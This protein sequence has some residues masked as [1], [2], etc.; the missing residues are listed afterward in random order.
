ML[1]QHNDV[2]LYYRTRL[3]S[4]YLGDALDLLKLLPDESVNLIMTSPPF[5]LTCKKDYGNPSPEA[6][7][8]WFMRFVDNFKRVLTRDGSM[9][10]HIGGSWVRGEPRKNLYNFELL[11]ELSKELVFIQDFYWYN[12]AKLPAPAEWVCKRRI[13]VKD[14]VDPIWW[15]AKTPYPKADNRRVLK[16][17]S[18]DMR[19][20]VEGRKRYKPK[21]RPSGHRISEWFTKGNGGSIPPNIIIASNTN[22]KSRYINL[23]RRCGIEPHPA[24]YPPEIPEFF[25]KFLT[26]RG[27]LVLDPFGGSNTTGWVAEKLGRRWVCFEIREDYLRASMLRFARELIVKGPKRTPW[28][29]LVSSPTSSGG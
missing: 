4:A 3:G 7:V 12:P 10:I 21:T 1:H 8:D 9:V 20:I 22:S 5:A 2:E 6:Y 13:R 17:Y 27:D 24:R 15:F 28:R 11:V 14:A 26:D 19:K 16:P 23:C 18:E 29:D 25:I